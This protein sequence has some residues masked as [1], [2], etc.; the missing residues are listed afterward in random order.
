MTQVG[1]TF[2]WKVCAGIIAL[3]VVGLVS[4]S[5]Y[6][7]MRRSNQS[8]QGDKS[9]LKSKGI[10]VRFTHAKKGVLERLSTQ[11]GSIQAY[12]SVNL[13]AK[14]A[15]FLKKQ[16]VD[17]GDHVEKNQILAVVDVPELEAQAERSRAG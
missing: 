10:P 4:G 6:I 14:V 9:A 2:Q 7:T 17:I 15:G 1:K 13:Y 5:T 11:P 16:N 12:E 8:S 3:A